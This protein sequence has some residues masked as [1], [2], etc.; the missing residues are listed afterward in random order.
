MQDARTAPDHIYSP[1]TAFDV[2]TARRPSGRSI[3]L[4]NSTTSDAPSSLT[5]NMFGT[6]HPTSTG[7]CSIG[8]SSEPRNDIVE[9][10]GSSPRHKPE[11]ARLLPNRLPLKRDL[12][13][14]PDT[15]ALQFSR[16]NQIYSR[17]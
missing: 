3:C 17:L 1:C 2:K 4:G 9:Y 12:H 13:L 6:V 5:H 16:E 10:V 8:L 15:L 14:A 11:R 7:T